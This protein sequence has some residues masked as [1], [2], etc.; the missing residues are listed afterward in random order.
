MPQFIYTMKGLGKVHPPDARVLEDIWLSFLPGAKI[1]VLGLN[2]AGKSS[3]LK[4][5]AGE[6][7]SF[8]GEAFPADGISVGFLPQE[9]KLD[10]AK[11]VL[12]NVE[13]G[14]APIKALLTRYD[15]VNA[16]LGEDLTPDEMDKVLEEQGKLQD[17]IEAANAWDLDS[18]LELA[19]DALRLPPPDADVMKLSGGERRRVALCRLLLQSPDLLLL[20]EPTNHLDAE[21]VAWL[22]RFLKD[23]AG[24][25]VAVT[26]DRYFLDNVA[27][28]ILELD[29]GRGIPWEGNYSSWLEQKQSRLAQEEKAE[30]RRQKTLERELEWI[31]MSP[32]ARQAKGKARLNAYED[33]LK[34]ETAKKIEQ[35]EIYIPPGPRLGDVVVEARGMRKGYGDLLLMDDVSFT[36]PRGGIVGVIGPNGAGK[37]TLFRMITGAER[38]DG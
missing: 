32:R 1:G 38:P 35:V 3:L 22:E 8:L 20:D 7:T 19:M 4:I 15:E 6:D 14:V 28:W 31:R 9:P 12:G 2:G 23:Y 30:T 13:E 26:H 24:T 21:S 34:E 11:T 37:T 25:V 33:L 18:R 17:R 29:R 5:M 10:P 27:G 36:L 16:K